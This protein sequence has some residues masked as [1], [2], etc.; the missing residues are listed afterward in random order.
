MNA[1]VKIS[2]FVLLAMLPAIPAVAAGNDLDRVAF[3]NQLSWYR[4]ELLLA[5]AEEKPAAAE[6]KPAAGGAKSADEVAKELTNP[7]NDL[8]KL[9]FKNRYTWYK[10]DLPG[11]DDQDNFTLLFQPVFPF[12]LG[13]NAQGDKLT[14]FLRPAIPFVVDQPVFDPTEPGWDEVTAMGDIGFDAALGIT[15]KSGW[16]YA[17]GMV[18]TLPTATDSD[19]AGKELMLGPEALIAHLHTW[20]LIG[21]FP[22]HQWDV[23]GWSGEYKSITSIQPLSAWTPGGGWSIG[24]QPIMTYNWDTHD[25]T[26][27]I[28]LLISKTVIMGKTPLKIELELNYY[29][30]QPD[31]FG[32]DWMV[33]LN[34][35]PVVPNFIES[36][37]KGKGR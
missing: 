34:L 16:I 6:E 17:F 35:T 4:A 18:G 33:G 15:K 19:V 26:V 9:T 5:Q 25:W 37:F 7:N 11:A 21:I 32:P 36:L 2:G 12:S 3:N 13:E 22:S 8:A 29:V 27:P 30:E 10:G 31:E 28:N 24:S 20:G 1:T 23:A 14:F